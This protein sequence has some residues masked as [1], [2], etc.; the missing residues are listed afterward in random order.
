MV[1]VLTKARV[2]CGGYFQFRI[3]GKSFVSVDNTFHRLRV[4]F[5]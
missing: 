5:G 3:F 2:H 4:Y 1:V